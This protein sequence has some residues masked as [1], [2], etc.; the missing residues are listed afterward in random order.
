ME[1]N[2]LNHE[3]A[4][5]DKIFSGSGEYSIDNEF[6]LPDYFPEISKVLKCRVIPRVSMCSVSGQT[7]NV[8]GNITVNL[9]YC[10]PENEI[11]GYEQIINFSKAFEIGC[12][13][14][15]AVAESSVKCEYVN[16]R[17]MNERKIEVHGAVGIYVSAF[18]KSVTG[19]VTD[20]DNGDVIVRRG[21]LPATSPV[22]TGEKSL[23]I[24]EEL[25]LG[26]GQPSIRCILKYDAKAVNKE[27][28][29]ISGKVVEKG[30]LNVFVLYCAEHTSSPQIYRNSIPYSQI[31]DI[32]GL[33]ENCVCS[34]KAKVACL[35]IKP[36]TSASGE[37]RSFML[38]SRLNFRA[39]AC[40]DDDLPVVLD[41][42]S[43]KYNAEIKTEEIKLEK[44]QKTLNDTFICKKALDN[45]GD[46]SSV[47]DIWC[48]TSVSEAMV[49]DSILKVIGTMQI[50][51]LAIGGNNIPVYIERPVEFEYKYTLEECKKPLGVKAEVI[52]NNVSFNMQSASCIEVSAELCVIA[53]IYTKEKVNLVTDICIDENNIK[54]KNN[55]SALII[56]YA[57]EG[58]YLWDIAR[59]Y[60]SSP[61]EISEINSLQDEILLAKKTLLIPIK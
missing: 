53:D 5:N 8:D 31:I 54:P 2:I 7:L 18:K 58:E 13:A 19:I 28:K 20:V 40:C 32:D 15:G 1:L 35:E 42:Y 21:L 44:I 45:I 22:G 49:N 6:T 33:H 12:D 52:T 41:A 23:L 47:V 39:T 17:C 10:S 46:I 61:Q 29:I 26:Q 9:I 14:S 48:E 36:R 38:T 30:E 24:E 60:N 37:T 57:D 50:C 25:E 55:D 43:T 34:A 3:A 59:K 16:C 4:Y 27:C 56:Y 51:V 11:F